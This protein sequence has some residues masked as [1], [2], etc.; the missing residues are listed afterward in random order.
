MDRSRRELS[1]NQ[2]LFKKKTE[3]RSP[4][5]Q[6]MFTRVQR[7]QCTTPNNSIV[8]GEFSRSSLCLSSFQYFSLGCSTS[9]WTRTL[10]V[11]EGG[12]RGPGTMAAATRAIAAAIGVSG[13]SICIT[14]VIP[15][16]RQR[17]LAVEGR[18]CVF[19]AISVIPRLVAW[20]QLFAVAFLR[21]RAR[22]PLSI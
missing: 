8:E 3:F 2:I 13:G 1:N 14:A 12:R 17:L 5:A 4:R 20:L 19:V 11:K 18:P 16:L 9:F 15:P 10:N 21:R 7:S 22:A 6:F